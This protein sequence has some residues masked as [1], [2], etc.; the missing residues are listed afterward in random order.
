MTILDE[1][2]ARNRADVERAK[3]ET[4]SAARDA[5]ALGMAP[6]RDFE[7]ALRR[8]ETTAL[9]AEVKRASPAKGLLNADFDPL[10]QARLYAENGAAAISVLTERHYFQSDPADLARIKD[11][12]DVPVLRKDFLFDPWQVGEARGMGADAV[13]LI[14]TVLETP[15]ICAML[16]EAER[17]GLGHLLE[18]YDEADLERALET[19]A[20]VFGIN[21]RDLKTFELSLENTRRLAGVIRS[22]RPDAVIVSESGI[23]TDEDIRA[24]R[25]WGANAALVGESL[26]RAPDVAAKVRE[27]TAA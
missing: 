7:A 1:I 8:S 3:L 24:V 23:F 17:F 6:C 9:I 15:H 20:R 5:A 4:D 12:V 27:L 18:V 11:A 25:S 22:E 19:P 16:A 26:M 14:A 13:L 10:E 2:I 21:N